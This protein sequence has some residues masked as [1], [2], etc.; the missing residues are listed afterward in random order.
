MTEKKEKKPD[1]DAIVPD[2]APIVVNGIRCK[3]RRIKTLEFIALIRVLTAGL[4]S[5]LGDVKL[6]FSS[7]ETITQDLS[8]LM[9]LAIPNATE[10]F[11]LLLRQMVEP[12]DE[13][14]RAAVATYLLDNP[15]L[16]VLIDI[17]ELIATQE[18]DD[19]SVLAGKL[20]AAWSRVVP[21][22]SRKMT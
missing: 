3:V 21:L 18:K 7:E 15:D 1:I 4:G 11:A 19:L 9:L 22:Y 14:D 10:E 12:I 16:D 6:D 8:A 17:F 13:G 5:A 20:Q 2:E